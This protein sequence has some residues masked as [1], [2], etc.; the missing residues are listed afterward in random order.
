ML[1]DESV[2]ETVRS[3]ISI[4][5]LHNP[6][7][8]TGIEEAMRLLPGVPQVA[9]FDTA[10]H[11]M[12]PGFAFRYTV[13]DEWYKGFG[14]R[15]LGS[16]WATMPCCHAIVFTAGVGENE[17]YVREKIL[18]FLENL[19]IVADEKKNCIRKQEAVIGKSNAVPGVPLSVMVIPTDEE[20]VIGYDAL[21]IGCLGC[22]TP[23]IYPFEPD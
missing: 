23:D 14:V 20:I 2:I 16:Y 18:S 9:V 19:K 5:P 22:A 7:N 4:A 3:L 1:I 21:Y 10:Y 8:I 17:D 11:S 12:L 13:P 15:K 6:P